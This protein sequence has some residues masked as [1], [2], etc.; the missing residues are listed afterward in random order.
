MNIIHVLFQKDK[1]NV[2]EIFIHKYLSSRYTHKYIIDFYNYVPYKDTSFVYME[3]APQ[4]LKK[5]IEDNYQHSNLNKYYFKT[6]E[7]S[8]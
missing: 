2:N 6:F 5:Y 4:T 1:T 7:I 3:Y 8:Y